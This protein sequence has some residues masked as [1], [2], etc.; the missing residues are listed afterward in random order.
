MSSHRR[1]QYAQQQFAAYQVSAEAP[2]VAGGQ[3]GYGYPG[4]PAG[5]PTGFVPGA[6]GAPLPGQVADQVGAMHLG[7]DPSPSPHD[8]YSG[9]VPGMAGSTPPYGAPAYSGSPGL[10]GY[11]A[12]VAPD[13]TSM[14]LNPLNTVDLLQTLPPPVNDLDYPPP[15]LTVPAALTVTHS[16]YANASSDYLRSTL[17]VIPR[18]NSLLKKSKLPFALVMR[19]FNALKDVDEPVPLVTDLAISR[20]RRCRTYINPYVTLLDNNT[21]WRCST[22]NLPN[23]IPQAFERDAKGMPVNM[24]E[25]PELNYGLVDYIASQDYLVT[26][27]QPPTYV[28][29]IDVSV[30][31]VSVG[32]VYQVARVIRESLDKLPNKDGRTRVAFIGVDSALTFFQIPVTEPSLNTGEEASEPTGP[33]DPRLLVVSD[34]EDPFL[35]SNSGLLVNLQNNRAQI[36]H[37]LNLLPHLYATTSTTVNAMGSGLKAALKLISNVGGKIV[38]ITSSLPSAGIGKLEVRDERK[39]ISSNKESQLFNPANNFYK[40]FAVECNRQNV[41]IDMFLISN[42]YQDVASLSNL[43]KFTG[44]ATY[45]YPGWQGGHEPDVAKLEHELSQFLSQDFGQEAMLRVRASSG[46]RTSSFS[47]HFFVRSSDLMT[48]PNIARDQAYVI[49]M[50]IDEHITKPFVCVQAALLYS[51]SYGERRI[52]VMTQQIPVSE[53]LVDIYAS[54]DQQAIAMWHAHQ[55]SEKVVSSGLKST[56]TWLNTR[57]TDLFK[58]YRSD[59][60]N[61]HTG[62][63]GALNMCSN[64]SLLPLLLHAI[65]KNV[66][67]RTTSSILSDIRVHSL[68]LLITMPLPYLIKYLYP[69]FYALHDLPEEAGVVDENGNIVLPQRLNLSGESFQSHGLYLIDDGQNMFLWVGNNV[70]NE[71]LIDA[72]GVSSIDQVPS[73][74][75]SMPVVDTSDLNVRIRN[76][77]NASRD[78]VDSVYYPVLYIIREKTE[79][80]MRVWATSMLVEDRNESDPTYVQYLSAIREKLTA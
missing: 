19:P 37:L 59:V 73:G 51:T 77:I 13:A 18:N 36:D 64:L 3:P 40:S 25:R 15:P 61:S 68:D 44:G 39:A 12:P 53:K 55:A 71:L 1:R 2:P 26:P 54:A 24:F 72:F 52:R 58:T 16:D 6:A 33:L 62:T 22:C 32:M 67:V 11:G 10:A 23:Q 76:I 63:S 7:P 46:I 50:S 66:S 75:A 69:E 35:P 4:A 49:D 43:P 21:R 56:H 42:N 30:N 78:R 74:K 14:P 20:C 9:G 79:P 31:A 45:F 57:I 17:N 60:L 70:V 48:F 80:T 8:P 65:Q 38:S 5:Q 29:L 41:S 34:L 27:P 28:F 47:G